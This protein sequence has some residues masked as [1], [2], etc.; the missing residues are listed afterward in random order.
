VDSHYVA[1]WTLAPKR[2]Y[3]YWYNNESNV[4]FQ[5]IWAHDHP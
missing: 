4:T 5:I 3:Y 2:R 1:V